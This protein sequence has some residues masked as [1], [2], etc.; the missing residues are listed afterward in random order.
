M[1]LR[2][3]HDLEAREQHKRVKLRTGFWAPIAQYTAYILNTLLLVKQ[4]VTLL[5][6]RKYI[7]LLCRRQRTDKLRAGYCCVAT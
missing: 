2:L 4:L 1:T 6:P 7:T 3:R 5:Y